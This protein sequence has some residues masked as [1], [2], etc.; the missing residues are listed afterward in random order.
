YRQEGGNGE[1]IGN[2]DPADLGDPG[3]ELDLELRQNELHDAGIHLAHEGADADRADDEPGIGG[4]AREERQRRRLE[5]GSC[6][7]FTQPNPPNPPR[8]RNGGEGRGEGVS[9]HDKS[10]T[11]FT[12]LAAAPLTPTL[13]PCGGRGGERLASSDFLVACLTCDQAYPGPQL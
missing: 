11:G 2:G 4:T 8:P 10:S 13:S 6:R 5:P 12:F 9:Q 1:E 3:L 7:P